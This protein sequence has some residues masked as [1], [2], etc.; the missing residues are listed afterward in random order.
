MDDLLLDTFET[1]VRFSAT[2][3]LSDLEDLEVIE[4]LTAEL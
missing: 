2:L 3:R 1:L 4:V